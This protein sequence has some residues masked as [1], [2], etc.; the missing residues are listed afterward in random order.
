MIVGRK[1]DIQET[2]FITLGYGY[3]WNLH[4]TLI[5]LAK[6]QRTVSYLQICCAEFDALLHSLK[7]SARERAIRLICPEA[8]WVTPLHHRHLQGLFTIWFGSKDLLKGIGRVDL[9]TNLDFFLIEYPRWLNDGLQR[10]GQQDNWPINRSI[11][12]NVANF[13]LWRRLHSIE[14]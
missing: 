4:S 8:K 5:T 13:R 11:S 10:N 12:Q 3:L 1:M 7:K 2:L 14:P 9:F 6:C